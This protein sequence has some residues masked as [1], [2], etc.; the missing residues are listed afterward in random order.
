MDPPIMTSPSQPRK[1]LQGKL[2]LHMPALINFIS[3]QR[4]QDT[5]LVQ[6]FLTGGARGG[7]GVVGRCRTTSDL[8]M[9]SSSKLYWLVTE[10]ESACGEKL[11]PSD[12]KGCICHFA[13]W[14]IH[15]FISKWSQ[16]PC[17]IVCYS[18]HIFH[19]LASNDE[20]YCIFSKHRHLQN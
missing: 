5:M 16:L 4:F 20:K 2:N 6:L 18:F 1:T 19:F 14:H 15:P 8:V 13:K 12:M 11:V 3:A 7:R 10:A 17:W 9:V